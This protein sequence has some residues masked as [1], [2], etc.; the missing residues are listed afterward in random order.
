MLDKD[1]PLTIITHKM[2]VHTQSRT[3]WHQYAMEIFPEN[4][5]QINSEDAIIYKVQSGDQVRLISASNDIGI[6]G[7][8]QVTEMIRPGCLGISF[9][10]GHSQSGASDVMVKDAEKVFYGGRNAA[11]KTTLKGDPTLGTGT[12]P[13]MVSRLDERLGNTPLVD[14]LAGIPDYSSTRVKLLK[15]PNSG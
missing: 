14:T 5:V 11:D 2:N 4:Y 15:Q 8:V 9:H 1:F 6:T 7:K 13:N 10:Y 12:N 3:G